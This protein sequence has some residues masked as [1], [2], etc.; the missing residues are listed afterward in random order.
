MNIFKLIKHE[1]KIRER[2][3]RC[4]NSKLKERLSAELKSASKTIEDYTYRLNNVMSLES[5][6]QLEIQLRNTNFIGSF[7]RT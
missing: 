4:V 1:Q 6:F 2:L 7:D 3:N 5:E